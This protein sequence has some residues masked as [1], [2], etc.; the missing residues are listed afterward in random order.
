MPKNDPKPWYSK[1]L[2]FE[3]T[4]CSNCCKTHGDYSFV[5]MVDLEVAQIAGYLGLEEE[6]FRLKY[7]SKDQGWTVINPGHAT[8]PFLTEEG[9][10]GVYPV[11]PMQCRTWPFWAENLKPEVWAEAVVKTCPGIGKGPLHSAE[12]IE[13]IAQETEDWYDDQ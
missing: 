8:C 1:G 2:R 7:C 5:Y 13:R 11:R 12:E 6:E 9:G 4:R 10:C 3:C